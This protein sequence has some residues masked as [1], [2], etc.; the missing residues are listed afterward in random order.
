VEQILTVFE[1]KILSRIFE[2]KRE[3]VTGCWRNLHAG[4]LHNSYTLPNMR[5][6]KSKTLGFAHYVTQMGEVRNAYKVLVRKCK[7]NGPLQRPRH[8]WYGH[9][10]INLKETGYEGMDWIH[11]AWDREH[12]QVPVNTVINF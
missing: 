3:N 10:K 11:V 4:E 6:I 5:V 8:T 1:K 2:L 12:C 9:I 7:G